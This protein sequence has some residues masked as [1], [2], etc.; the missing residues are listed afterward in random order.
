MA[1]SG[2]A[3]PLLLSTIFHMDQ[4]TVAGMT[5][6]TKYVFFTWLGMAVLLVAGLMLRR[7]LSMAQVAERATCSPL[8]VG[9]IEKRGRTGKVRSEQPR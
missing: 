2:L 8:T 6:E 4:I 9:R 5:I 3:H 7:N 1:A